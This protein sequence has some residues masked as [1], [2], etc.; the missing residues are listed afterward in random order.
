MMLIQIAL[1][2]VLVSLSY[3]IYEKITIKYWVAQKIPYLKPLFPFGNILELFKDHYSEISRK[4]YLKLKQNGAPFSVVFAFWRPYFLVTSLDFLKHVF[5]T[6]IE[7][8]YDHSEFIN[9]EADPFSGNLMFLRGEQWKRMKAKVTPAFTPSKLKLMSPLIEEK[10]KNLKDT[11]FRILDEKESDVIECTDL[12]ARY[13]TDVVGTY[14]FGIECNSLKNPDAEFRQMF[15][16]LM[17]DKSAA[18]RLIFSTM[19]RRLSMIFHVKFVP[20]YFGDFF[21]RVISETVEYR[22]K[23]N[24]QRKDLLENLI[25][26]RRKEQLTTKEALNANDGKISLHEITAVSMSFLLAGFESSASILSFTMLELSQNQMLQNRARDS[27]RKVIQA[28]GEISF[29]SLTELT[30]LGQ[31][32]NG[33]KSNKV[34]V[35][36]FIY[37]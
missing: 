26:I 1:V 27:V 8:F 37:Y 14:A 17:G 16:E 2:V 35:H 33:K 36:Q 30:F 21:H 23:N 28:H 18:W 3:Y 5:I 31:C 9:E 7:H 10:A 25:K 4:I 20:K 24:I 34:Y 32:I 13:T 15:R 11:I 12:F 22:E 29:E 6:D 19:F